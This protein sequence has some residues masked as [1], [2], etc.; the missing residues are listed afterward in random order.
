[1]F[2]SSSVIEQRQ[3]QLG[4]YLRQ[5]W[6]QA[7]DSES[8]GNELPEALLTF[9]EIPVPAPW[10]GEA[11]ASS[12]SSG[13]PLA[14]SSSAQKKKPPRSQL[15]SVARASHRPLFPSLTQSRSLHRRLQN[16]PLALFPSGRRTLSHQVAMQMSC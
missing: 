13:D 5:A 6:G 11:G 10:A 12:E 4:N 15:R 7:A 14:V 1:M 8:L 3:V 9:L 16:R 2:N